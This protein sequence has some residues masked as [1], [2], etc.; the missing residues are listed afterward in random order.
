[1][2]WYLINTQSGRE[3]LAEMNLR[4]LGVETFLPRIRQNKV[5]RQKRQ[6][7]TGPLF[8]GYLFARFDLE[9]LYRAVN[10]S[11]GVRRVVCFGPEPVVVEE[12]IIKSIQSRLKE[13]FKTVQPP[14]LI[15]GQRVQ[16]Q[17]GPFRGIEAIF[18]R[19]MSDHQR[20]VLFLQFLSRK[21]RVVVHI[22]QVVG[23]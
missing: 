5:I 4:R 18:E 14:K 19:K 11:W 1:M 7:V 15:P 6:T 8:K 10:F 2:N 13:G 23:G 17:Q 3:N 20:V 21:T 9:I 16:I 12:E 22:D